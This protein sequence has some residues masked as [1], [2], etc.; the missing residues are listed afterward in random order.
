MDFDQ[1]AA[2]VRESFQA[3]AVDLLDTMEAKLL[4]LEQGDADEEVVHALFRAAHSIKGGSGT[5]GLTAV[6]NFTHVVETLLDEMREQ[7]LKATP[8]LISLFL[9][10]V[11]CLRGMLSA[12]ESGVDFDAAEVAAVQ[13]LLEAE[14]PQ[15]ES[16]SPEPEQPARPRSD[17]NL[18]KVVFKPQREFL[19]RGNNPLLMFH[20]LAELGSLAVLVSVEDLPAFEELTPEDLYLWWTL[21]LTS[22]CAQQDIEEVF[23]WV[24]DDC[25]LTI[26]QIESTAEEAAVSATAESSGPR[27]PAAASK[28]TNPKQTGSIRVSIDKVD[29]LINM[30]GELVITQ[31][32]LGAFDDYSYED[33]DAQTVDRIRESITQLAQNT[34]ELQ[35]GVMRIRMLPISVVFQR[36]PRLVHDLS[37]QLGKKF[38]LVLEGE[39]TELDKTV[40]EQVSEPLVHL[41]RN[42][43]DHGLEAPEA[44]LAK[45][46]PETGTLTLSAF[47]R[48]GN[49]VIEI[50]DDGAGLNTEKIRNK[51]IAQGLVGEKDSL[52]EDEIHALIF[53]PG[54][55]TADQVSDV[56]GRGVGMD[57]VVRKIKA[58]SG[59]VSIK[60]VEGKGTTVRIHLPLTMAILDGQL[61]RIGDRIFILPLLSIVESL[62]VN[63]SNVSVVA[64]AAE[65]YRLRNEPKPIVRLHDVLGLDSSRADLSDALLVVVENGGDQVCLVVDEL[66]AQQQVVVKS[67]EANYRRVEG[68]AGATILG[69]GTVALILDVPRVVA[70]A[71]QGSPRFFPPANN[72]AELGE[73]QTAAAS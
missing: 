41:V 15:A 62:Q 43:L 1:I 40:L 66:L 58:L 12:A 27:P 26:E 5:C 51:A 25:E 14:L 21:E 45:G 57:V 42:S 16:G 54:F 36:F 23:A 63:H 39:Q 72:Q 53:R 13:Q 18:W 10:S 37:G 3:E 8:E 33:F 55:S 28:P 70:A 7:R 48:S 60:S 22:D 24:E 4:E 73:T 69:D 2:A 35:E 29:A 65:V 34:R 50:R 9:K 31:S 19:H 52:S 44:R 47:H 61:I 11:D 67:L 68:L 6:A 59:D 46:K 49:A 32:M 56:S 17:G 71:R 38:E 20:E 64:N 30:V